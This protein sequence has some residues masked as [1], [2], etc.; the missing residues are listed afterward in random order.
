MLISI[1]KKDGCV[2]F[3]IRGVTHQTDL[4]ER[5]N[6]KSGGPMIVLLL[7]GHVFILSILVNLTYFDRE[8]EVSGPEGE[9]V[10][11]ACFDTHLMG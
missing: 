5:S 10:S 11:S 6:K 4:S 9:L 7:A 1:D 3:G 8:F 2:W